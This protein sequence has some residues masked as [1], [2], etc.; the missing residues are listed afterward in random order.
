M[1]ITVSELQKNT[2]Q[3]TGKN[4][5]SRGQLQSDQNLSWEYRESFPNEGWCGNCIA[6]AWG[7]QPQGPNGN[8]FSMYSLCLSQSASNR[9]LLCL[10]IRET[11][12]L[13]LL[14][15][16]PLHFVLSVVHVTEG[17][18]CLDCEEGKKSCWSEIHY[19][20]TDEF[21][22]QYSH[23]IRQRCTVKKNNKLEEKT[24]FGWC[25]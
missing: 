6:K 18:I 8:I 20:I 16:F 23:H 21:T 22:D 15:I 13:R 19:S 9:N 12:V 2:K 11:K 17:G 1:P 4:S 24:S 10:S 3:V 25:I 7:S 5:L 14:V